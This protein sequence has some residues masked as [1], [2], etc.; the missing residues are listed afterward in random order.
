MFRYPYSLHSKEMITMPVPCPF[1]HGRGFLPVATIK[2]RHCNGRGHTFRTVEAGFE[3]NAFQYQ[4]TSP[5]NFCNGRGT[6]DV[7]SHG[8]HCPACA[9]IGQVN[10]APSRPAQGAQQ[11]SISIPK[12]SLGKFTLLGRN[13]NGSSY[14][15]EATISQHGSQYEVAWSLASGQR[16]Y[17]AGVLDD[18]VLK[19]KWE[20]GLVAYVIR[21]NGK[22][23][24]GTWAN[25]KGSEILIHI[26]GH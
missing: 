2:C 6:N 24:D 19:I 20:H 15:G 26:S 25:G 23:L 13:P 8:Y 18:D 3:Q 11:Q 1:C 12:I 14:S 10:L 21:E 9:G 7:N 16:F 17:G 4:V 5:C 22:I